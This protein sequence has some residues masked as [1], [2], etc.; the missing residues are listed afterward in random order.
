[1]TG[2]IVRFSP[3]SVI[4]GGGARHIRRGQP[5]PNGLVF[6]AELGLWVLCVGDSGIWAWWAAARGRQASRAGNRCA[7]L[8]P[9]LYR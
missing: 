1:M 8:T 4:D 5:S 9:H 6:W 3:T 7:T 2:E